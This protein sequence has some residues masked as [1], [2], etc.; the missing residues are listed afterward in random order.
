MDQPKLRTAPLFFFA[1]FLG[2]GIIAFDYLPLW[3]WWL[4]F[5]AVLAVLLWIRWGVFFWVVVFLIGY[6]AAG[7]AHKPVGRAVQLEQERYYRGYVTELPWRV[8]RS[9]R[10]VMRVDAYCDTAINHTDALV[11]LQGDGLQFLQVGEEFWIRVLPKRMQ[12]VQNSSS[13]LAQLTRKGIGW[14]HRVRRQDLIRTNRVRGNILWR[15]AQHKRFRWRERLRTSLSEPA[16]ALAQGLL[17]G[18]RQDLYRE[19][20]QAFSVVGV[21][22]LF[23]VSGLHVGVVYGFI[24][25]LCFFLRGARWGILRQVLAVVGAGGFMLIVGLPVATVRAWLMLVAFVLTKLLHRQVSSFNTLGLATTVLLLL[26]P[27]VL[28]TLSFQLSFLAVLGIL[29]VYPLFMRSI[30]WRWAAIVG[31]SLSAQ[32]FTFPLTA[33]YFHTFPLYGLLSNIWLVPMLFVALP[34]AMLIGLFGYVPIVTTV[35]N[36]WLLGMQRTV[37]WMQQLS[38]SYLYPVYWDWVQLALIYT[39]LGGIWICWPLDGS[40]R[41]RLMRWVLFVGIVIFVAYGALRDQRNFTT[42]EWLFVR[43]ESAPVLYYFEQGRVFSSESVVS[44]RM[45]D[46][47]IKQGYSHVFGSHPITPMQWQALL[48]QRCLW[49]LRGIGV[50]FGCV[51][52][53]PMRFL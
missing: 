24:Y 26:H 49:L 18:D 42:H 43:G 16:S 37:L 32:V 28:F 25:G 13:Y 50:C 35:L 8:D 21:M 36:W 51:G 9:Y 30:R 53:R 5:L 47:L 45:Q 11:Q 52:C 10:C 27:D 7:L 39:L 48:A 6:V 46:F 14:Q 15:W 31:V 1:V 12:V 22:H 20:L 41:G 4:V 23:A 17:L 40:L 34:G 29:S 19:D 44:N 3:S 38:Y 2:L 33:H